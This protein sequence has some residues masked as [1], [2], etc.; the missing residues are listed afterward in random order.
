MSDRRIFIDVHVIQSVPPSCINRDDTG[1]PKSAVYGGVR[2]AR[3]SSQS[4]KRA[5]R[6]FFRERFDES[7]LS[8][9]TLRVAELVAE[10]IQEKDETVSKEA[11]IDMA[12]KIVEAIKIEAKKPK[13]KKEGKVTD[14]SVTGALFF[15]SMKQASNLADLAISKDY[16]EKDVKLGEDVKKVLKQGNGVEIALFGRMVANDPSLN[17]DASSQVAHGISTHAVDNEYDYFTAV[18]DRR[19]DDEAGAA[20]IDTVE[21][22]SSTLYRYATVAVHDLKKELGDPGVTARALEEFVRAFVLSMPT[23]KQNTFANRVPPFHVTVCVR[24]DQPVNL[25]GAFEAPV[26]TSSAGG[27]NENSVKKLLDYES[28]VCG[29][30]VAAPS[31]EWH[32]GWCPESIDAIPLTD[33]IKMVGNA[34]RE[35]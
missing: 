11:A 16:S 32:A 3:V 19:R 13:K 26:R 23:G 25:V 29:D 22:N 9:R 2:R 12:K 21:F 20:M 6:L 10:K 4:W 15:I 28:E 7:E 33:I 34:V 35:L 30:F 27:Y 17:V 24:E 14:V 5:M 8:V 31:L 18:D 1:S